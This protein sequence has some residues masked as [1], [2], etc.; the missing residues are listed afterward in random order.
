MGPWAPTCSRRCS[1]AG[2]SAWSAWRARDAHEGRDRLSRVFLDQCLPVALLDGVEV[3]CGDL[4]Q[5]LL[6]LSP[7]RFVGLGTSIDAVFHS[8]ARLGDM[9][10]YAAVRAANVEG[11]RTVLRLAALARIPVHHLSTLAILAPA[12]ADP[13]ERIDED[14]DLERSAGLDGGYH[15]SRWVAERLVRAAG[16]RGL[17]VSI[18]RLGLVTGH[19][20]TGA[21]ALDSPFSRVLAALVRLRACPPADGV[22]LPLVPVDF[23]AQA[24]AWLAQSGAASGSTFHLCAPKP[25]LLEEVFEHVR[26]SGYPLEAIPLHAW[27]ERITA[28]GE[29]HAL[30]DV[31]D[32][33]SSVPTHGSAPQIQ[34]PSKLSGPCGGALLLSSAR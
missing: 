1:R 15:Q 30:A 3:I 26:R 31:L 8:G 24:I 32:D 27:R 12:Q 29:S 33:L 9:L 18:Y 19:S 2:S 13:A 5:P 34:R 21:M 14:F 6:G 11:T 7:E 10:P 25:L 20:G 22:F 28:L 17:P 4:E 16:Q 23:C